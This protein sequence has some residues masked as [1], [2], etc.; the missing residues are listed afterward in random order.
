MSTI[1]PIADKNLHSH[2]SSDKMFGDKNCLSQIAVVD[3]YVIVFVDVGSFKGALSAHV[4]NLQICSRRV[5]V[6]IYVNPVLSWKVF[7]C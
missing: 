6:L 3:K 1:N 7:S 4:F 5:V 2:L